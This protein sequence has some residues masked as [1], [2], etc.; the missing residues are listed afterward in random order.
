[1]PGVPSYY[2]S[3]FDIDTLRTFV[4]D[5]WEYLQV[6]SFDEYTEAWKNT[7]WF[8]WKALYSIGLL[9]FLI[10]RPWWLLM[11]ATVQYLW[12]NLLWN[13][14]LK[15]SVLQLRYGLTV[16]IQFQLSL[17]KRQVVLEII[18]LGICVLLYLLRRYIQ[19]QAYVQRLKRWY[20]TKQRRLLKSYRAT[21][22]RI[23]K[24]SLWIAMLFPHALFAGVCIGVKCLIPSVVTFFAR[25]TPL[26]FVLAKAY[27]WI[28][29][30]YCLYHYR[31]GS[32]T[33]T[34]T[35]TNPKEDDNNT[36]TT[37]TTTSNDKENNTNNTTSSSS[38]KPFFPKSTSNV[39]AKSRLY[40]PTQSS[41]NKSKSSKNNTMKSPQKKKVGR[42]NKIGMKNPN[43]RNNSDNKKQTAVDRFLASKQQQQQPDHNASTN[44]S[45]ESKANYWLSYWTMYALVV[46]FT[47]VLFLIPIVGRLVASTTG[48]SQWLTSVT[49]EL[50]LFWILWIFGLEYA[51]KESSSSRDIEHDERS[52]RVCLR[53]LSVLNRILVPPT[54]KL[55]VSLNSIITEETWNATVVGKV[56][57]VLEMA[58]MMKLLKPSTSLTLS[59]GLEKAHPF[60]LPSLTL[61][62]PLSFVTQFGVIYVQ[63]IVPICRRNNNNNNQSSSLSHTCESL[64]YWVL[65]GLVQA[66][67]TWWSPILWWIPFSNHLI[68][69]LWCRLQF[70]STQWYDVLE[71]ELIMFGLLPSSVQ[72]EQEESVSLTLEN[73]ITVR[74]VS[75]VWTRVLKH[76][77]SAV[78]DDEDNNN[79]DD[80]DTNKNKDN[81][82]KTSSSS[83]SPAK[84]VPPANA[85]QH[86]VSLVAVS[87]TTTNSKAEDDDDDAG[88]SKEEETTT[89]AAAAKETTAAV[90]VEP[91]IDGGE[92]EEKENDKSTTTT[93]TTKKKGTKK[94]NMSSS[95]SNTPSSDD[96]DENNSDDDDDYN[97]NDDGETK[98]LSSPRR[99]RRLQTYQECIE[100]PN[101]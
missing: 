40:E 27:P 90:L 2:S 67:L 86:D 47:R 44:N 66:V 98:V 23:S 37:T 34:T 13:V 49:I 77:P 65:Q 89:T 30:I 11:R 50:Q 85:F 93:T 25:D 19:K 57:S 5:G 31:N 97:N 28:S 94:K 51:L 42:R 12:T 81:D 88:A 17:T 9:A 91:S 100:K 84:H 64:Q 76:L 72:Q 82:T 14:L 3:G 70:V 36:I 87:T 60:L 69:L 101:E 32:T 54:Q 74:M 10:V 92:E 18:G 46:G 21:V 95:S 80:D 52:Y 39:K 99:S 75:H 59:R 43:N 22:D 4:L 15:K 1:M 62:T 79:D 38:N 41:Q 78:K 6:P 20:T 29:T 26:Y 48:K 45:F 33:T 73:T 56:K 83:S 24:T 71:L 63:S 96:D 8:S 58:T 68:F 7:L 35:T 61:F 53:P 55:Y 16:A